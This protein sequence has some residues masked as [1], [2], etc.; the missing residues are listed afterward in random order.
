MKKIRY[1]QI[2]WVLVYLLWSSTGSAT[3]IDDVKNIVTTINNRVNTANIR[4]ADLQ[5]KTNELMEQVRGGTG[6]LRT[7]VRTVI[8]EVIVDIQSSIESELEG[9]DDFVTND[10]ASFRAELIG[11]VDDMETVM[12]LLGDLLGTLDPITVDLERIKNA[13]YLLPDRSLYPL[14]RMFQTLSAN[15]GDDPLNS[16]S[17][18]QFRQYLDQATSSLLTLVPIIKTEFAERNQ[19]ILANTREL[20]L[21]ANIL[22]PT[23][24]VLQL[25]AKILEAASEAFEFSKDVGIHGYVHITV[26]NDWLGFLGKGLGGIG[27]VCKSTSEFVLKKIS[28]LTTLRFQIEPQLIDSKNQLA[29]LYLP[30]AYGG[31]LK[32]VRDIVAA[33]IA[34]SESAGVYSGDNAGFLL[35]AGNIAFGDEDY[36]TAYMNYRAA[37]QEISS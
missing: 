12:R 29:L 11:L 24:S 33:N 6:A 14:Y 8:D 35:R 28:E 37:Y 20:K 36:R 17:V 18:I 13:I 31:H 16:P 26:T 2:A 25:V 15:L 10:A 21:A 9:R 27:T 19:L 3:M 30:A 5:S 7:D 4:V 34:E 23:S 32:T 22:G 1:T